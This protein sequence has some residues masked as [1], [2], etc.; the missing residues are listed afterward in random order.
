MKGERDDK[1]KGTFAVLRRGGGELA[2]L[3]DAQDWTEDVRDDVM[4]KEAL[5]GNEQGDKGH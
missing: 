5:V 1:L 4:E 2:R 3:L